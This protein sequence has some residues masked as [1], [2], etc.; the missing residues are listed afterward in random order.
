MST[1]IWC[2]A[3]GHNVP[4]DNVFGVL[5]RLLAQEGLEGPRETIGVVLGHALRRRHPKHQ[6]C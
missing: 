3:Y 2:V 5:E 4:P 1:R 6:L